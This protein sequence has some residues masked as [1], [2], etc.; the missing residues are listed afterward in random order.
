[1]RVLSSLFRRLFL[2][3]LEQAFREN[4]LCFPGTIA[5]LG[6]SAAFFALTAALRR[7][8]WVLTQAKTKWPGLILG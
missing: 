7:I 4:L 8:D 5:P 3:A 1:M 2:E 6:E